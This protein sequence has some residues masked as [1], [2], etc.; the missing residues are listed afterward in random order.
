MK[1][2]TVTI[3]DD[4]E[5]ELEAYRQRQDAPPT[6]TAVMQAALREYLRDQALKS[7]GYRPARGPLRITPAEGSARVDVSI[8]HDRY[9]AWPQ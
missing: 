5:R 3:P 6:I 8:N 4:L 2:A 1:R 7:R 9:L